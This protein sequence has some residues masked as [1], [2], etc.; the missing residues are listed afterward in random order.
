MEL[1]EKPVPSESNDTPRAQSQAS[2]N[3][4]KLDIETIADLGVKD[5][6]AA[7]VKGGVSSNYSCKPSVAN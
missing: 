1:Y 5:S 3:P 2:E 7:A 6:D 4:L